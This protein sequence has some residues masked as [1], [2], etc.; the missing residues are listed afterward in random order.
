MTETLYNATLIIFFLGFPILSYFIWLHATTSIGY[1]KPYAKPN[2]SNLLLE[3]YRDHNTL[4]VKNPSHQKAES[5]TAAL[6]QS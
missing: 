4:W 2:H 5:L 1:T 6:F 3:L